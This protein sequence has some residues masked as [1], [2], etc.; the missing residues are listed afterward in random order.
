MTV[1]AVIAGAGLSVRMGKAI[2]KQLI[3][4]LDKEVIVHT[5]LA[6]EQAKSIKYIAVV[7]KKE[8]KDIIQGLINKYNIT[9][10][11]SITDGGNTR[12]QSVLKGVEC[13][14]DNS[15][16]IAVHDGA[17][18]LISPLDI[19]KTVENAV[20]YGASALG[21]YVKDT[22]KIVDKDGF[23]C[24]TPN[25]SNT[26]AIQTPQVF[27][28]Q[29]YLNAVRLAESNNQDYTDDC[30][31]MEAYGKKVHV[32]IGSYNNIKVTTPEDINIAESIL[33]DVNK[34]N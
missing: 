14:K 24:N 10:V 26:I 13:I 28:T 29:D 4:I 20:K 12:Q 34:E 23:I 16:F 30:Q 2:S 22:I 8:D 32:T 9:K 11:I 5:L 33:K 19:D 21:V 7:C 3:K 1:N 31:L 6:F 25:R 15:D 27:K 18:P 17:R